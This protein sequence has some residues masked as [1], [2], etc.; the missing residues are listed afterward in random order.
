MNSF[1]LY[2]FIFYFFI[3]I[4]VHI[5]CFLALFIYLVI[6][7]CKCFERSVCGAASPKRMSLSGTI[8]SMHGEWLLLRFLN[9]S[10]T[11]STCASWSED[12]QWCTA[13]YQKCSGA[14][15]RSSTLS[16]SSSER[17]EKLTGFYLTRC[18]MTSSGMSFSIK[19]EWKCE[20]PPVSA[21]VHVCAVF[22]SHLFFQLFVFVS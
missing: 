2:L 5:M 15:G 9:L 20:I 13:R 18:D 19:H 17:R 14:L 10:E 4:I 21:M 6:G 8:N 16:C 7:V 11:L 3:I 1:F 12:R 22:L